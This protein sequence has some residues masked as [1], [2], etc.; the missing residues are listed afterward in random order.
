MKQ[1]NILIVIDTYQW[2]FAQ[3]A[4]TVASAFLS[5][6]CIILPS[7][8]LRERDPEVQ[9][10]VEGASVLFFICNFAY[11]EFREKAWARDKLIIAPL[12]HIDEQMPGY[13]DILQH[14]DGVMVSS[15]QWKGALRDLGWREDQMEL[16]HYGVDVDKFSPNFEMRRAVRQRHNIPES[17]FVLGFFAKKSLPYSRKGVDVFLQAVDI[18]HAEKL[19]FS[20][21]IIGPGWL[22]DVKHLRQRGVPVVYQDFLPDEE[23][24]TYYNMLDCYVCASRIEGGPV[25]VLE[26]LASGIPVISTRVGIAVEVVEDYITGFKIDFAAP[27]QIASRAAELMNNHDLHR[28]LGRKGR[29]RMVEAYQWKHAVIPM[30]NLMKKA[31]AHFLQSFPIPETHTFPAWTTENRKRCQ[32]RIYGEDFVRFVALLLS[33]KTFR[34]AGSSFRRWFFSGSILANACTTIRSGVIIFKHM[35]T[36]RK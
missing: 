32:T 2:I 13:I 7:W 36:R 20:I 16:V 35:L 23:L 26:S 5:D 22:D 4:R 14:A 19:D 17:Q 27:E 18:L 3:I 30:Q 6:N 15:L 21:L 25:P 11:V 12:H 31:E 9:R 1:R 10:I 8:K 28:T 34:G 29:T 24:P 33:K